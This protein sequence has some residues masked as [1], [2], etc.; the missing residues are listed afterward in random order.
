MNTKPFTTRT[1]YILFLG[2]LCGL[3]LMYMF[4]SGV[5][6]TTPNHISQIPSIKLN[7]TDAPNSTPAKT[8]DVL[9]TIAPNPVVSKEK[10]TLPEP[11]DFNLQTAIHNQTTVTKVVSIISDEGVLNFKS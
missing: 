2:L 6:P 3:C 1:S 4:S 9:F 11:V 10:P 8:K 5:P 7:Y